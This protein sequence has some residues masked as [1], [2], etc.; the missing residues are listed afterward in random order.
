MKTEF[1]PIP[2]SRDQLL[3]R[4]ISGAVVITGNARLASHLLKTIDQWMLVEGHKAWKTPDVISWS[5]WLNRTFNEYYYSDGNSRKSTLINDAQERIIWEQIIRGSEANGPLLQAAAT[6]RHAASSWHLSRQWDINLDDEKHLNDDARAFVTWSE[7]YRQRLKKESWVPMSNIADSLIELFESGVSIQTSHIILI[8]FDELSTQQEHLLTLLKKQKC[9]IEWLENENKNQSVHCIKASHVREEI[10]L[11]A[12]WSRAILDENKDLKIGVVVPELRTLRDTIQATF[13]NVLMPQ[14]V[15][16]SMA[17]VARPFNISLGKPLS[18]Y[19]FI[20]TALC[21]LRIKNIMDV[22]EMA[23]VINSPY[24]QGW[25]KEKYKRSQLDKHIRQSG[26]LTVKLDYILKCMSGQGK[27]ITCSD[28]F[29]QFEKFISYQQ[30]LP[31]SAMPS[32]W[33]RLFAGMLDA[34]GFAFGRA[35]SSEEY[36]VAQAWNDLLYEMAALDNTCGVLQYPVMLGYLSRFINERVFQPKTQDS[37]IQVLGIMEAIGLE[38]DY[39]WILGLHDGIWPPAPKPDP[40]IPVNLQRQKNIP[41]SCA[42]RELSIIEKITRRLIASAK[43]VVISYPSMNK[44]EVLRQSPLLRELPDINIKSLKQWQNPLWKQ[45]VFESSL[46][47][48]ITDESVT[49]VGEEVIKGGSQ[50]IKLQSLCPFRA[51]AEIRLGA[52]S[53]NAAMI[54][55]TPAERGS[56]LHKIL[57]LIWKDI[58]SQEQLL[59]ISDSELKDLINKSISLVLNNHDA[60]ASIDM[61]RHFLE[62]ERTRLAQLISEWMEIEKQRPAF[63]VFSTEESVELDVSGLLIKLKLDRVDELEQGGKV[64]IDYKT[65]E[66]T[67]S[68]WFGGRPQE[69]QLPLYSFALGK[70]ISA[71]AFAQLKTGVSGFKG[72]ASDKDILPGVKEFK[73]MMQSKHYES[74]STLLEDWKSVVESLASDFLKGNAVVDPLEYPATCMY[75]TLTQFCRVNEINDTVES[76]PKVSK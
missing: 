16:I 20:E 76:S 7:K 46:L 68:H 26:K 12:R 71:L 59:K 30:S 25:A 24:I 60:A 42:E 18:Q 40:F 23:V 65:G 29:G 15:S 69:P 3:E 49:P 28:L 34:V 17:Q 1:H 32:E 57:E 44:T 74:W 67:P 55:M 39:L 43:E 45:V 63:N 47:E 4:I 52:K 36:Q 37:P 35:L 11:V 13:D 64:V 50:I 10:E 48:I 56:I 61:P 6:A 70:N 33:A 53:V 38:F 41:H 22:E 66:V 19:P 73:K 31:N 9:N 5:A 14:N 51:F 72:V 54:G 75:C 21:I 62:L 58:S 27:G 8:G 2:L